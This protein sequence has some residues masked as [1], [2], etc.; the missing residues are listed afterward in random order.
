[1]KEVSVTH[2]ETD[3]G[4]KTVLHTDAGT[5]CVQLRNERKNEFSW[6]E[7]GPLEELPLDGVKLEVCY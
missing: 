5:L 3:F 7:G 6:R 4:G 1:M 2:V